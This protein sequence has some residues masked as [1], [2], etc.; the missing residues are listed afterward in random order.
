MSV[1][2]V[3]YMAK[4]P[5]IRVWDLPLRVFH[6]TLATSFVVAFLTGD[7]PRR[8]GIHASAGAIILVLLLFRVLWSRW[9]TRWA[10]SAELLVPVDA[11]RDFARK[12]ARGDAPASVGHTP[13]AAWAAVAAFALLAALTLTG[14][15]TLGGEEQASPIAGIVSV[16]AGITLHAAH[17]VLAW[18]AV[19]WVAVHLVGVAKESLRLRENL[20]AAM[21][22]G[23]KV[24]L[25][26][27]DVPARSG[28]AVALV[29]VVLLTA[30]VH[31][32]VESRAAAIPIHPSYTD[33]CGSCHLA[34]DPA[35]LPARSW[36]RM[37]TEQGRHFGE[38][39]Y[40]DPATITDLRDWLTT[41]AAEAGRNESAVRVAASVPLADSPQRITTLPWWEAIH[42]DI[43]DAVWER[44]DIGGPLRC[45]ACHPDAEEGRFDPTRI[46]IPKSDD[47]VSLTQRGGS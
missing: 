1:V 29:G 47:R 28:A 6:W 24:R 13:I 36:E 21:I 17:R 34:F 20:P 35:L 40:L 5:S 11:V 33:E 4:Q 38:D 2:Y 23:R 41:N 45:G 10:R 18:L 3:P 44:A 25:G 7:E 19:G 27:A 16:A 15:L 9:G 32:P 22:S 39:L 42:A 31:P 14:L 8:L 46:D 43:S 12:L 30:F 26:V 37:L